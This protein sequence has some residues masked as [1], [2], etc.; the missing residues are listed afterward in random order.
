MAVYKIRR[1][2]Y[3]AHKCYGFTKEDLEK[4]IV[5]YPVYIYSYK[6]FEMEGLSTLEEVYDYINKYPDTYII[7]IENTQYLMDKTTFN[8]KYEKV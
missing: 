3:E 7:N 8:N 2:F 5:K 4:V 6:N 1:G